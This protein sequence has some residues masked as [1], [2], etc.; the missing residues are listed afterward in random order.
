MGFSKC[1]TVAS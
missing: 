1:Y